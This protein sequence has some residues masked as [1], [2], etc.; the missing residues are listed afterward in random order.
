MGL[1]ENF[2]QVF[3]FKGL[4]GKVFINQRLTGS[5]RSAQD[6]GSGLAPS[7]ALRV[8][9]A[10]RLNL[11]R[12]NFEGGEILRSAQD[13]VS[14]LAPSTALRVTPAK[15]LNLSKSAEDWFGPIR[16]LAWRTMGL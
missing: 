2:R 16:S 12:G 15:R 4:R 6:F 1:G 7:T 11:L 3:G 13:F 10:K 8:T 5:V 14:G 9:P